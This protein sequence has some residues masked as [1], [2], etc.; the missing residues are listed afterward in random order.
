M[1]MYRQ[2]WVVIA[3]GIATALALGCSSTKEKGHNRSPIFDTGVGATIIDPGQGA[4]PMPDPFGY[5][6]QVPAPSGA[7][8]T[9]PPNAPGQGGG[10]GGGYGGQPAAHPYPAVRRGPTLT[11]IGGATTIDT[12]KD[13]DDADLGKAAERHPLLAPVGAAAWPI[14]KISQKTSSRGATTQQG[15]G[16]PPPQG[17]GGTGAQPYPAPPQDDYEYERAQIEAM[18]RAL[19]QRAA[20]GTAP[21]A[22]GSV[23][24][25]PPAPAV[26]PA[27]T[28]GSNLTIAQELA[29]LRQR[30]APPP[31][32]GSAVA[33]PPIAGVGTPSHAASPS[34]SSATEWGAR[35]NTQ[36]QGGAPQASPVARD[37]N[38]DGRPDHWVE[39]LAGNERRE[40]FDD[41]YDG[42]P[43]RTERYGS[44]GL[45][46]ETHEDL[47]GD[48]RFD[49]VT[50]YRGGAPFER[51]SDED[52]DGYVDAW[53]FFRGEEI[54]R[55]ERDTDGDGFRDQIDFFAA[56]NLSRRTEDLDGD[57]RPERI[58]AFDD[59]GRPRELEED[60]DGDGAMDVR[61]FYESGRLVRRELLSEDLAVQ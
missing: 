52:A 44:D 45:I 40:R 38:R 21:P 1:R 58:T 29:A 46:V 54:A 57:G 12:R 4:P 56:G 42:R 6:S 60:Q 9:A 16:S 32:P 51:Q 23:G 11:S 39:N 41:D 33:A 27:R 43:D 37:R 24:A 25:L 19:A 7:P 3:G 47:D 35:W 26:Q 15:S 13:T 17:A 8:G 30:Q 10:Y 48:G 59:R 53:T 2:L 49:T 20:T 61:S 14:R 22:G 55:L 5:Y 31:T 18:E 28:A 34:G 50:R 36:P